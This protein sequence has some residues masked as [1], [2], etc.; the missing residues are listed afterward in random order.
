MLVVGLSAKGT[1]R[2]LGRDLGYMVGKPGDSPPPREGDTMRLER[3]E[4][5]SQGPMDSKA[6]RMHRKQWL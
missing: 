5:R 4:C 2:R 6:L 1:K 3:G